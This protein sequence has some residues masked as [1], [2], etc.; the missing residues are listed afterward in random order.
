MDD[1]E[2]A[3]S[4]DPTMHDMDRDQDGYVSWEEYMVAHHETMDKAGHT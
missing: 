4:I 2:L 1:T 3:E